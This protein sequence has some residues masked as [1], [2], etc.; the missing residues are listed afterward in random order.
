MT[1]YEALKTAPLAHL[2]YF[3]E[4][5]GR[6][7]ERL[8]RIGMVEYLGGNFEGKRV[9]E[10]GSRYGKM[11]CLFGLLGA[12][13]TGVDIHSE[14]V[15]VARA[16]AEYLG[17]ESNVAFLK[18]GGQLSELRP[19][20]FDIVFLKSVMF[21][22]DDLRTFCVE[23]HGLLAEDGRVVFV[24]NGLGGPLLQLARKF[25]H[26]GGWDY[27]QASFMTSNRI[28]VLESVFGIDRIVR[29]RIPPI[30]L[31]C[32]RKRTS[33]SASLPHPESANRQ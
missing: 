19:R 28:E 31:F 33:A 11:S 4:W 29:T 8:V 5:G 13:V 27:S 10:I 3:T 7:W 30:Y 32:G 23:L 15:D 20:T 25:R 6:A 17:V 24:E 12:R 18:Y 1:D 2:D 9:L 21:L 26:H 16:E 14:H 22:F